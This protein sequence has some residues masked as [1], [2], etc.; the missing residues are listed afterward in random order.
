MKK[1]FKEIF[2]Y[3]I[4]ILVVVLIRTFLVTPIRVQGLSMY[5][6]LDDKDLLLLAKCDQSYERFDIVILDY[7]GERLVKRIIG[8]P[9]ES[10]SYT[11]NQLYINGEE[12]E[13]SFLPENLEFSDFDTLLIGHE[14]IPEGNYFVVGDNRNNSTDSRVFGV[15][16]KKDILGTAVFRL[17][18]FHKIGGIS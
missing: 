10:V 15:V 13:E 18:P 2:P 11:D 1:I 7:H 16:N 8:L 4:I 14:K 3:I 5:P 6:T 9:G 12:V 17:Y